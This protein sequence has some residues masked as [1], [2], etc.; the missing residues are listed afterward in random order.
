MLKKILIIA[1]SIIVVFGLIVIAI[2]IKFNYTDNKVNSILN[3]VKNMTYNIGNQSYSLVNGK[4]EKEIAPGSASKEIVSIF[5]EP[6]YGDLN[7][8]G[9][10]DAAVLLTQESGGSGMFYYAVL[11]IGNNDYKYKATNAMLLGDRIAPQTVEIHD[12]RAVYNYAER[13]VGESFTIKPSVGKSVWVYLDTTKNEIGE[14]VK[15][16]EGEA[17]PAK[18]NLQMKTW[19]WIKTIFNNDTIVAPK[20]ENVFGITFKTDGTFSVKTDCNSVGGSFVIQDNK[21]LLSKMISTLMYCENSQEQ[22]FIKTLGEVSDFMFTS[23]GELILGLKMDT[24][25]IIFR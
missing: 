24:G 17:D 15:D 18:M 8:D 6:V 7:G 5:G 14:W 13:R 25:S 9:L 4:V 3:D 19:N 1:T 16:F 21:I 11:V 22:E 12:G 23:K 2:N 10:R 20:K